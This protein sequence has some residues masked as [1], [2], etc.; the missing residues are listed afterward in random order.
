MGNLFRFYTETRLMQILSIQLII[1][2]LAF[3]HYPVIAFA[4]GT[5]SVGKF[6]NYGHTQSVLNHDDH[7]NIGQHPL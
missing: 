7:G 4:I 1:P 2:N 3:P 6:L 5:V